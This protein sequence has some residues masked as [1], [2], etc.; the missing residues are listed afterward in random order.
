MSARRIARELAVIVMPQLPKNEDKLG[1]VEITEIVDR[2]VHMLVDYAKQNLK[3]AGALVVKAQ[4]HMA[5]CDELIKKVASTHSL[6]TNFYFVLL[7]FVSF[8]G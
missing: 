2:A 1:N 5:Q 8:S 3:E 6:L 4:Q 7:I